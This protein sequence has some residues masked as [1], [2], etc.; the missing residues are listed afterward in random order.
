M[1]KW[2]RTLRQILYQY[3]EEDQRFMSQTKIAKKCEVSIGSVNFIVKKLNRLGAIEIKPQGFRVSDASRILLYWANNRDIYQDISG[4]ILTSISVED[5]EK[6]LPLRCAMT[7][8][9]AFKFKFRKTF[10]LYKQIHVYADFERIKKMFEAA[11]A[12]PNRLIILRPD[13][14]LLKLSQNKTVPFAQMYVDLWQ[15]GNPGKRY[16]S[17]LNAQ[18]RSREIGTIRGI[19]RRT[20]KEI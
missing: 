20:R 7:C 11:G 9:S 4:E 2:E 6:H 15:V 3:F 14:H 8:F 10:H 18:I 12:G 17:D 13:P 1:K 5:I 16:I 19:I